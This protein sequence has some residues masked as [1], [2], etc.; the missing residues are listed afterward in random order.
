MIATTMEKMKADHGLP[1]LQVVKFD[2]SPEN[3][4]IFR[5]RF[6]QMVESKA[7]Y[8]PSKMARLLQFLEGPALLAVLR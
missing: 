3:Y 5:Q 4:P 1:A 2:G 6:H 8:E 7:L